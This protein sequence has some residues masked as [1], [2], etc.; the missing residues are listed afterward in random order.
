M[1][2]SQD[3]LQHGLWLMYK[4]SDAGRDTVPRSC[5]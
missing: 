5:F 4:Q 3:L 1:L 2:G